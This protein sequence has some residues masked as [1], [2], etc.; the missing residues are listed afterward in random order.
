MFI[1]RFSKDT[2]SKKKQARSSYVEI[3]RFCDEKFTSTIMHIEHSLMCSKRLKPIKKIKLS[4]DK[5]NFCTNND[6][7][8]KDHSKIHEN[9]DISS[10]CLLCTSSNLT[11]SELVKHRRAVH[12]TFSCLFCNKVLYGEN[13]LND[14]IGTSYG[15]EILN[16]LNTEC[17]P[18]ENKIV[19]IL[20]PFCSFCSVGKT[21]FN[22]VEVSSHIKKAHMNDV[23][24]KSDHV[25]VQIDNTERRYLTSREISYLQIKSTFNESL[26][27]SGRTSTTVKRRNVAVKSTARIPVNQLRQQTLRTFNPKNTPTSTL[28]TENT[29]DSIALNDNS[30]NWNR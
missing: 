28:R 14:H 27:T 11:L 21:Y 10:E 4:C 26:Q 3:C 15:F 5:C 22:Y 7:E 24:S 8:F 23:D 20:C 6:L 12:E 13:R 16:Q 2:K 1:G 30:P 19:H 17:I 29:S 18:A 9:L 25:Q